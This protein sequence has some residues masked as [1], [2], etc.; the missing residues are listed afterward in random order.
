MF[1]LNETLISFALLLYAFL[2]TI[3]SVIE[4]FLNTPNL[5]LIL[6]LPINCVVTY[7]MFKIWRTS[8]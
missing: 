6:S 5:A 7:S 3:A 4:I 2:T 1:N 8:H